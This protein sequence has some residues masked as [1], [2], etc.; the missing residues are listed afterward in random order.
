MSEDYKRT[1]NRNISFRVT[2]HEKVLLEERINA[3]GLSKENYYIQSAVYGRVVVVGSRKNIDY[4]VE[5]I[6]EMQLELRVLLEQ[7]QT[8]LLDNVS[9]E[10]ARVKDEYCSMLEALLLIVREANIQVVN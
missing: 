6:D 10:I 2:E 9:D 7:A 4:I 8:G 3:S 1:R 5:R